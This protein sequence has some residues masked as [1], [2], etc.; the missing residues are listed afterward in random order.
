MAYWYQQA[1]VAM[2]LA[3][4]STLHKTWN[5]NDEAA[6]KAEL[7]RLELSE[8]AKGK[9]LESMADLRV[10]AELIHTTSIILKDKMWAGSEPHP[11]DG[12][13]LKI[14][15]ALRRLDESW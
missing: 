8:E 1:G 14:M 13:A 12:D 5:E 11:T 6:L 15:A 7:D 4:P 2:L 9:A 3:A 10:N